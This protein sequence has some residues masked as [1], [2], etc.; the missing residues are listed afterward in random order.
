MGTVESLARIASS[1]GHDPALASVASLRVRQALELRRAS[2]GSSALTKP[3][4]LYYSMLNLTRAIMLAFVGDIGHPTHG[5]HFDGGSAGSSLLDCT[6]EV[7]KKPSPS[8]GFARWSWTY[9]TS[10]KTATSSE[11]V[12]MKDV[13][14]PAILMPVSR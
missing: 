2:D 4:T 6:A 12:S 11:Q 14:A 3:L 13:T 7:S 8:R 9:S 1:K 10:V 5:L